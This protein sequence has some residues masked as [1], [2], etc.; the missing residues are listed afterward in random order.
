MAQAFAV[1]GWNGD[2]A[3]NHD[4]AAMLAATHTAMVGRDERIAVRRRA[5]DR[6]GHGGDGDRRME[7]RPAPSLDQF[8]ADV[9]AGKI[10]YYVEAGRGGQAQPHGE[11]IRSENHSA[12]HARDIADWVAGHYR[13]TTIGESLVYRLT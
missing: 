6:F 2:E 7:R 12:S 10:T 3:T 13:R 8:I 11:V 5:R 9:H 1:G 4:L